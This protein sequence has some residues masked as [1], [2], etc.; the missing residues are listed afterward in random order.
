MRKLICFAAAAVM[1]FAGYGCAV[2]GTVVEQ[3]TPTVNP[4]LIAAVTLGAQ[5]IKTPTLPEPTETSQATPGQTSGQV[6]AVVMAQG[7]F[8]RDGPGTLFP[9]RKLLDQNAP[10]T[11]IGRA[12]GDDWLLVEAGGEEGWIATI[13]ATLEDKS[14]IAV[15]PVHNPAE[16]VTIRGQVT[17]TFGGPVEGISFSVTQITAAGALRT[18]ATTRKDGFFYA[19]LPADATGSWRVALTGID[20]KSPIVDEECT[21]HGQFVPNWKDVELPVTGLVTF[22]YVSQ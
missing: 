20:C 14:L 11:V 2:D 9:P 21:F 7:V 13:F 19:Y 17:D 18:D 8:L 15:L 12:R 16:A 5:M 4:T 3:L 22:Q 1:L 10:L 6:L